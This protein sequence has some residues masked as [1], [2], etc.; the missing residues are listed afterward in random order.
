MERLSIQK[1]WKNVR[2]RKSTG[3]RWVWSK[4]LHNFVDNFPKPY[5]GNFIGN[6]LNPS[7]LPLS[8]TKNNFNQKCWAVSNQK[9]LSL[10]K[11]KITWILMVFLHFLH[12]W[13]TISPSFSFFNHNSHDL[14]RDEPSTRS[15]RQRKRVKEKE[16]KDFRRKLQRLNPLYIQWQRN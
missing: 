7:I 5:I 13:Q 3:K 4:F 9:C 16:P 15:A 8:P 11:K 6:L 10:R 14:D 1:H 2:S 12:F